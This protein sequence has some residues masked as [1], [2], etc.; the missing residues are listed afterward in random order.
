MPRRE[1]KIFFYESGQLKDEQY[2]SR[3][4]TKSVVENALIFDERQLTAVTYYG[5]IVFSHE[6]VV[7]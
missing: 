5:R 3:E 6:Q 4:E 1:S 7:E 2:C